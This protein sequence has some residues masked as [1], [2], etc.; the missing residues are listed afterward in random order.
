MFDLK[1]PVFSLDACRYD[2]LASNTKTFNKNE[3]EYYL[4]VHLP[5]EDIKDC[6]LFQVDEIEPQIQEVHSGSLVEHECNRP[7]VKIVFRILRDDIGLH[8]YKLSFINRYTDDVVPLYFSYVIQD[9][10][11]F[12]PYDYMSHFRQDCTVDQNHLTKSQK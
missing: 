4:W 3:I 9:D 7:W 1:I 5:I 11:P 6:S 10:Y 12:K 2:E 8:I